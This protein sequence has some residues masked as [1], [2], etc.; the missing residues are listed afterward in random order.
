MTSGLP[1][2]G[3]VSNAKL[4]A[5]ER[6]SGEL[7]RWGDVEHGASRHHQALIEV[8]SATAQVQVAGSKPVKSL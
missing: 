5:G 2:I 7:E 3:R 6:S 4:G 1:Q 8:A